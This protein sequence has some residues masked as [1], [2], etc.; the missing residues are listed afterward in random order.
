MSTLTI[1][2]AAYGLADV[3]SKVKGMVKSNGTLTVTADNATFGDSWKGTTK[4]LVLVYRYDNLQPEVRVVAENSTVSIVEPS[5]IAAEA[6]AMAIEGLLIYGAAYGLGDVTSQVRR[7]VN[8]TALNVVANNATYGDTWKGT[9]KSMVV[10]YAGTNGPEVKIVQ[11]NQP[12]S[13]QMGYP[14]QIMGATYGP[15]DVTDKV[16]SKIDNQEVHLTANNATFGDSWKGTTKS[17][18]VT[19]CYGN[20][21]PQVAVVEENHQLNITFASFPTFQP[22]SDPNHLQIL[23]AGYGL[24]N[25]TDRCAGLVSNQSL[26]VT[27]NNATFGDT[28]KGTTK[29]LTVTYQYGQESPR[30]AV[31]KENQE[32]KIMRNA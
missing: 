12:M 2:G 21:L 13:I 1:L 6:G 30:T 16:K 26:I 7:Q 11:E 23:G 3:T 10:V 19:Y 8:G 29:T 31:V 15:Q 24:G 27:A 5:P 17:L 32:L 25:V 14:L 4:S 28:W 22:S 20:Q 18:T 9:T